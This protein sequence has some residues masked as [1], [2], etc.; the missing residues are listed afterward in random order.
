M[1]D[2][3]QNINTGMK[4]ELENHLCDLQAYWIAAVIKVAGRSTKNTY[5]YKQTCIL[6]KDQPSFP[7]FGLW[8]LYNVEL[9]PC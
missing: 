9:S 6:T 8:I 3:W 7:S 4:L 5:R 2:H 1:S